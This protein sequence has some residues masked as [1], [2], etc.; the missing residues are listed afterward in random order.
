[1]APQILT[2]TTFDIIYRGALIPDQ[3][4]VSAIAFDRNVSV[5]D[6]GTSIEAEIFEGFVVK[7]LGDLLKPVLSYW[8]FIVSGTPTIT[9]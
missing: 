9:P 4:A 8:T 3:L 2:D 7:S 6:K 1:M 5:I